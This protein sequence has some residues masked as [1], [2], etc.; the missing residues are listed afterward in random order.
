M[1]KQEVF[2]LSTSFYLYHTATNEWYRRSVWP[3]ERRVMERLT[4]R[5][6]Y[7]NAEITGVDSDYLQFNL[8]NEDFNKVAEALNK[9]A[10]YEDI[11]PTPEQLKEIDRLYMEQA[12]KLQHYEELRQ[13][14]RLPEFPCAD[15]DAIYAIEMGKIIKLKVRSITVC[16]CRGQK[17]INVK[18]ENKDCFKNFIEE[19]FGKIVFLTRLDA[20]DKLKELGKEL[21]KGNE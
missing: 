21:W 11:G 13:Q 7:G 20:E 9:L 3:P 14:G 19:E 5:D 1:E 12:A 4:E 10:A 15:G 17:V 2:N 6:E 18:S 16:T 8:S